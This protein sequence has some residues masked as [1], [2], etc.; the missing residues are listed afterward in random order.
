MQTKHIS[1]I[2][3][4][5]IKHKFLSIKNFPQMKKSFDEPKINVKN[6]FRKYL[7]TKIDLS[8]II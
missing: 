4:L 3:F 1:I 7:E 2:L 8:I 5:A 6:R